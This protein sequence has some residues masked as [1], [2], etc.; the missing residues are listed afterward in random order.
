M[1]K[2]EFFVFACYLRGPKYDEHLHQ[3]VGKV[4]RILD[5]LSRMKAILYQIDWKWKN[6]RSNRQL[7]NLIHHNDIEQE[8]EC[9]VSQV[10]LEVVSYSNSH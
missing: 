5:A 9:E 1:V 6:Q 4:I 8:Y 7:T 2:L 10:L 3:Q